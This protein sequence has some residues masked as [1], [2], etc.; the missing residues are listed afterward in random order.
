MILYYFTTFTFG[1][2]SKS[3]PAKGCALTAKYTHHA[4]ENNFVLICFLLF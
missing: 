4:A 1:P 3:A 2:R